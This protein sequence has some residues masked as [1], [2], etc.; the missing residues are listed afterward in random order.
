MTESEILYGVIGYEAKDESLFDMALTHSSCGLQ[1]NNERLEFLGDA[2]LELISS[3][4]LFDSFPDMN[5]GELS[6]LRSEL[7]CENGLNEWAMHVHFNRFVKL[8]KGEELSGGRTKPSIISDAV[9][10]V[11]AAVY[12]DGG[13]ASAKSF[14]EIIISYLLKLKQNGLLVTD[15]KTELQEILQ[16]QGKGVPEYRLIKSEGPPHSMTFTVMVVCGDRPLGKGVGHSK[17]QAE[18][19]AAKSAVLL[20]RK[21]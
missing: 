18:Q 9:E 16:G 20:L 4:I 17:K 6:K 14:V 10:A 19:D 15:A 3:E 7:V 13:Y 8:G 21:N 1:Y 12:I 11:I 2:V 5:E